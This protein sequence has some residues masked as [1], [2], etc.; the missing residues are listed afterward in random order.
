MRTALYVLPIWLLIGS[1]VHADT[2]ICT[3]NPIFQPRGTIAFDPPKV[4][5]TP[6]PGFS[7][8]EVESAVAAAR[9]TCLAEV[10][11]LYF[12]EQDIYLDCMAR[13]GMARGYWIYV[14]LLSCRFLSRHDTDY[15]LR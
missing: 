4:A 6:R 10:Q 14:P 3:H 7:S 2:T 12:N 13:I 5:A 15:A 9:Q 11:N 8:E 1:A